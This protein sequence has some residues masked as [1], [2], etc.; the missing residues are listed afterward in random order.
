MLSKD[1]EPT[2]T[3][4]FAIGYNSS[5]NI[6]IENPQYQGFKTIDLENEMWRGLV[7]FEEKTKVKILILEKYHIRQKLIFDIII[8]AILPFIVALF[9]L[10]F[11]I[12]SQIKK[13]LLPLEFLTDKITKISSKTLMQFRIPHAPIELKPFL[14]SFNDLL[15]RLNNSLENEKR[16]TDFV[17]HELN[18]P[19]SIIKLQAQILTQQPDEK[20]YQETRNNLIESVNRATHLID[21]LLTL[22]RLES[23]SKNFTTEKFNFSE[24]LKDVINF[25]QKEV[26]H[27]NLTIILNDNNIINITINANKIYYEI[28]LKNLLSNAIK[29]SHKNTEIIVELTKNNNLLILQIINIGD[30]LSSEEINKLFDNFYRAKNSKNQR[31]A[32]S[33]LGLSIVKKIADLHD[34][35]ITFTSSSNRN[36]IE[37]CQI[38]LKINN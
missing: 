26:F 16:F 29:Y 5:P 1:P 10:F 25:Y 27:N 19:L 12:R 33:G 18:T 11:L 3:L 34:N 17:A 2:E 15:I 7:F 38:N 4:E 30:N 9:P 14:N 28:M 13:E 31:I 20:I 6:L 21:Q 32:G 24:L 36:C 23:D 8:S 22:S 37:L 35:K